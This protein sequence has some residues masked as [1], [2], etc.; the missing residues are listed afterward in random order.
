MTG[1][2]VLEIITMVLRRN[3]MLQKSN[4]KELS[5]DIKDYLMENGAIGVGISTRETLEDSPLAQ[6]LRI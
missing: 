5:R 1:H 3:N 6:T 2:S 4:G